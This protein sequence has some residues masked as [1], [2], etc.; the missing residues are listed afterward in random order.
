MGRSSALAVLLVIAAAV[1]STTTTRSG[2]LAQNTR[3]LNRPQHCCVERSPLS[4]EM[5]HRLWPR[6][7][8]VTQRWQATFAG[9]LDRYR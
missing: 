1:G 2:A 4:A 7:A 5:V 8:A 9:L 6:E 3:G